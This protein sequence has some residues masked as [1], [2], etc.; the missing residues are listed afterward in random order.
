[1]RDY[2]TANPQTRFGTHKYS[3]DG[4]GLERGALEE[5]FATYRD[6]YEVPSEA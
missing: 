5:R 1:M 4:T 6:R 2:V 3:L